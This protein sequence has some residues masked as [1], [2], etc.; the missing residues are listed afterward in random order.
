MPKKYDIPKWSEFY[1]YS[2][3]IARYIYKPLK[4]VIFTKKVQYV[5]IIRILWILNTLR[6]T[7]TCKYEKSLMCQNNQNFMNIKYIKAC[8]CTQM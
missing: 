2:R 5:K 4:T 6:Y 7:C 1:E 3:Y 8:M